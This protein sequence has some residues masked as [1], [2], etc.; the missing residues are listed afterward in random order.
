MKISLKKCVC[1]MAA[2]VVA[3][4]VTSF[5]P[6]MSASADEPSFSA[7]DEIR[8]GGFYGDSETAT[9]SDITSEQVYYTSKSVDSFSTDNYVPF[10]TPNTTLANSC[11]A[12]GGAIIV[13]FY[14]KYYENLIPGYTTYYTANGRY[15][16]VDS[17]YIP[18]L[19]VD[20]Y[21]L[22]RTN[23]DDVGVS[24]SDCRNG[25][26]SYVQGKGYS[27]T[28]T[29]IKTGSALNMN[30][31]KNA[32]QNNK[33]ILL[34][35]EEAG[36]AYIGEASGYDNIT[37]T[38][39]ANNHIMV[40]FGYYQVKYYNG[41]NNFRTDTYFYVAPGLFGLTSGWVNVD[42]IDWLNNGY[43]VTIND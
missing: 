18:A 9:M 39:I 4:S 1:A 19:M 28:Y 35:C 10:Y 12:T 20:L 33:P 34:F 42:S 16:P 24:E 11:G 37:T 6:G 17:T 7:S 13:G 32:F 26:R 25:L 2:A 38:P 31:C 27:L 29:S 30:A 43:I 5:L 14:D 21:D 8:Y 40:A 36:V 3:F 41:S 22:M 23:V 15:K